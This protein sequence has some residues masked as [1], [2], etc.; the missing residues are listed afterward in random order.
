M[1]REPDPK[2]GPPLASTPD[3]ERALAEVY[4]F[5]DQEL[6]DSLRVEIASHL[7]SCNPCFEA[8]DFEAELRMVITTKSQ[9]AEF[10]ETLRIRIQEKLTFMRIEHSEGAAPNE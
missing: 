10:P 4:T 2:S 3:C 7:D 9:S 1:N 5:L 6:T 8:F